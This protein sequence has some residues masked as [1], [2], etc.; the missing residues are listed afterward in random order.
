MEGAEDAY[1]PREHDELMIGLRGYEI[2]N[3]LGEP[4]CTSDCDLD[5]IAC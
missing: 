4:I 1:I 3:V 2:R 5:H